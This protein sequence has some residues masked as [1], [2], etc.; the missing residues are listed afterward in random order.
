[1]MDDSP[2]SEETWIG[3]FRRTKRFA[4]LILM[5][6]TVSEYFMNQLFTMQFG[7]YFDYPE[8]KILTDI[9]FKR[10]LEYLTKFDVF[11][12]KECKEIK[13]FQELRNKLF[14]GEHPEYVVWS[15]STKIKIMGEAIDATYIIRDALFS[16]KKIK[17][18][19]TGFPPN[20]KIKF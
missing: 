2:K 15:D 18:T 7:F 10:K 16:N 13:K 6:W 3:F 1:M 17:K 19:G 5:A 20:S 4:D 11:S 9:S 12:K 14:H 8:A